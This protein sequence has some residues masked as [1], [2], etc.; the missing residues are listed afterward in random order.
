MET[1][2]S[3]E[4]S[5]LASGRIPSVERALRRR[6]AASMRPVPSAVASAADAAATDRS[7][8]RQH[9]ARVVRHLPGV[10][11]L[12]KR[13]PAVL[14]ARRV[15]SCGRPSLAAA[16]C[17]DRAR[18]SGQ[19][20]RRI[21]RRRFRRAHALGLAGMGRV[22]RQ[23]EPQPRRR[24]AVVGAVRVVSR[25]PRL[26]PQ[27]AL[28]HAARLRAPASRRRRMAVGQRRRELYVLVRA[29]PDQRASVAVHVTRDSRTFTIFLL[30]PAHPFTRMD[31]PSTTEHAPCASEV[32]VL[33]VASPPDRPDACVSFPS[34]RPADRRTMR[35]VVF[36]VHA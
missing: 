27:D 35:A 9:D 14:P 31:S 23:A 18:L 34:H 20:L 25:L 30:A 24:S 8:Y 36:P 13:R 19:P 4:S 32:L 1:R 28:R 22:E 17:R 3:G 16:R 10:P 5:D 15:G 7:G 21:R 11:R 33:R 12:G 6:V 2:D 29:M 26:R